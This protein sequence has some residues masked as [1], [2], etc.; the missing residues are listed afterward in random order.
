MVFGKSQK[1]AWIV[2]KKGFRK[3]REEENQPW[4]NHYVHKDGFFKRDREDLL[5]NILRSGS[6][7]DLGK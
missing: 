3:R 2:K 4:L 5:A 1:K 6:V 7:K